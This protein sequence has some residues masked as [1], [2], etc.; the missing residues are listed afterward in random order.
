M[1]INEII[2]TLFKLLTHLQP[3]AF[4]RY[5]PAVN[6]EEHRIFRRMSV[7]APIFQMWVEFREL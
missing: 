2:M 7:K 1:N 6:N 5:I 3:A 4:T